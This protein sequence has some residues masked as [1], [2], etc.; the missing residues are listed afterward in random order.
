MARVKRKV[1]SNDQNGSENYNPLRDHSRYEVKFPDGTTDEIEANIIAE[2]MVAE[3]DPEGRQ[4]RIFNEI[5]DHRKETTAL[6]VADG[7]F[8]TSAG[9]PVSKRTTRGWHML[10]EWRDGSMDWHKLADIKDSYPVQIAEY[11]VANGITH[12]PAFK[13]WIKKVLKRRERIISKVESK[14]WRSTH[15]FGIEIPDGKQV[16]A[17]EQNIAAID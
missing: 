2:F 3:C 13:W 12:K 8:T 5:S 1:N 9:N 16:S 6:N 7:S 17:S 14:Y 4:Y 15:K 11:A 10:I